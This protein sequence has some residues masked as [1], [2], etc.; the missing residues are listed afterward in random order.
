MKFI[1]SIPGAKAYQITAG[2]WMVPCRVDKVRKAY[3]PSIKPFKNGKKSAKI[4]SRQSWTLEEDQKLKDIILSRG[5]RQWSAIAI[6]LNTLTHNGLPLRKGK[7][8][9]ERWLGHLSPAIE[10]TKWSK[11]E[12]D[13]LTN[14]QGL[15]GNRWSIIAKLLPGRTENQIKNRWRRMEKI[16]KRMQEQSLAN[17]DISGLSETIESFWQNGF[18]PPFPYDYQ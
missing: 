15:L 2:V 18:W 4:D 13:I 16:S 5:A 6:E 1:E 9:R 3:I 14:Q 10:K 11:E 8:C 17:A 7:Q 12:D